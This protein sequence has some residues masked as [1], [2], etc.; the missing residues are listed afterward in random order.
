M[1]LPSLLT[2][3]P[4]ETLFEGRRTDLDAINTFAGV[5]N[6]V[7]CISG[8]TGIGKTALLKQFFNAA[9]RRHNIMGQ[10]HYQH[11]LWLENDFRA[12]MDKWQLASVHDVLVKLANMG[13]DKLL[14]M[15]N[16]PADPVQL[17]YL[18]EH[19]WTVIVT[20]RERI[21]ETIPYELQEVSIDDAIRIFALYNGLDPDSLNIY[22]T[23]MVSDIA[24]RLLQHTLALEITGKCAGAKGWSLQEINRVLKENGFNVPRLAD[25]SRQL[26]DAKVKDIYAQLATIFPVGVETA[27]CIK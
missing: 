13:G 20:S 9:I 25:I 1:S 27:I 22:E 5:A 21:V 14:C 24:C 16:A 11:A 23:E 26:T 19:K 18:T 3:A 7:V 2:A 17:A 6:R 15:D 10:L 12:L 8:V 4:I